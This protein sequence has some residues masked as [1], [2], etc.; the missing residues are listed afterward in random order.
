M[1]IVHSRE[2]D[3]PNDGRAMTTTLSPVEEER[4]RQIAEHEREYNRRL[5]EYYALYG[6]STATEPSTN[7][8]I[9]STTPLPTT[10]T[11]TT[12]SPYVFQPLRGST[13]V[14]DT[15]YTPSYH[16]LATNRGTSAVYDSMHTYM[17]Q[18][19][20]EDPGQYISHRHAHV[21]SAIINVTVDATITTTDR[22]GRVRTHRYAYTAPDISVNAWLANA[23]HHAQLEDTTGTAARRQ[24]RKHQ[25]R[26]RHAANTCG[27]LI[28]S[29]SLSFDASVGRYYRKHDY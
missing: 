11:A 1:S 26:R 24:M 7:P 18:Q 5:Q 28:S 6:M 3:V 20:R 9:T 8:P 27:L 15:A 4:Q 2:R 14:D 10:T 29:C 23:V 16:N 13:A 22:A 19:G 17:Q 12:E 21:R 25:H